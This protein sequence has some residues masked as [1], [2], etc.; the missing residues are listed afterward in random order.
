M[1]S[2]SNSEGNISI[3]LALTEPLTCSKC[4]ISSSSPLPTQPNSIYQFLALNLR[5][6]FLCAFKQHLSKIIS[7]GNSSFDVMNVIGV[8]LIELLV[9][10]EKESQAELE[11]SSPVDVLDHFWDKID[12]DGSAYYLSPILEVTKSQIGTAFVNACV[13]LGDLCY[14]TMG[15]PRACLHRYFDDPLAVEELFNQLESQYG[16][17]TT[18]DISHLVRLY[19]HPFSFLLEQISKVLYPKGPERA[20][21]QTGTIAS[22]FKFLS[23]STSESATEEEYRRQRNISYW[24]RL[25]KDRYETMVI[26][27]KKESKRVVQ[28]QSSFKGATLFI[29]SVCDPLKL[30]EIVLQRRAKTRVT[31]LESIIQFCLDTSLDNLNSLKLFK[32]V[33]YLALSSPSPSSSHQPLNSID[34]QNNTATSSTS[35][36][37]PFTSSLLNPDALLSPLITQSSFSSNELLTGRSKHK[38]KRKLRRQLENENQIS[39]VE[40]TSAVGEVSTAIER[41]PQS[42]NTLSIAVD[43]LDDKIE[44][45]G[46]IED[47]TFTSLKLRR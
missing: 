1:A 9:L 3:P 40:E 4:S 11:D 23:I 42:N 18:L 30:L 5:K 47:G 46:S 10:S 25:T 36:L 20:P 44:E 39:T 6:Y 33:E 14:Q 26:R 7:D 34:T 43:T 17:S 45:V 12:D 28:R 37:P 24:R 13:E 27:L 32:S 41:A 15:A 31:E 29:E 8:Y 21:A 19:A 16:K 35:P 22:I 2:A 38:A